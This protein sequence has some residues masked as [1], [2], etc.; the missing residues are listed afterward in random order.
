MP[1]KIGG[2]QFFSSPLPHKNLTQHTEYFKNKE[3]GKI[4]DEHELEL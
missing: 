1:V 4:S 3:Q 2:N